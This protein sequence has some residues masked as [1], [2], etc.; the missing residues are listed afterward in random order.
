MTDWRR[1]AGGTLMV[2]LPGPELDRETAGW[3]SGVAPAG[4]ILFA[5]N[6][7]TPER[8]AALIEA[9]IPL[10]RRPALIAVDQEGGRVSRLASWLGPTPAA[11]MLAQRG[12]RATRR[13]AA[14]T[15]R[16]LAA[17]G[18][19]LDFAPVV[20]LCGPE[21]AN[22]IGDRSYGTD[23][24]AVTRMAGAFLLGLQ[25]DAGVAGCLKHFPGLG[26]TAVDSHVE[27]P[28]VPRSREQLLREDLAPYRAL[29][30]IAA[31]V[32]IGH[33]HYPALDD[34]PV[35]ASCSPNVVGGLLRGELGFAGPAVSDDLEMGA[36][37]G[38]DVEG[39]AAVTALAAGCDLLL[40][41]SDLA[42]ADRALGAL[43]AEARRSP[44]LRERLA[45]AADRVRSLA[46]ARPV[47]PSD[48]GTW[49]TARAEIAGFPPRA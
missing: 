24:G 31:S 20:D 46:A 41:C 35:P 28:V 36:V 2:G 14:A 1:E 25:D 48:L 47:R 18:F 5:R 21:R 34:E 15:G 8:T 38:R 39:Q 7:E 9:L 22:G 44:A 10:L 19:N 49:E 32:M 43:A 42:R 40:Y 4:V 17:L 3:L 11:A 27:L 6:L 26:D 45:E 12:E 23:P 29:G 37:A 16:S 13:F 33:G 30:P